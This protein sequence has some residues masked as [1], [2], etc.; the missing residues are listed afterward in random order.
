MPRV[1]AVLLIAM[2]ATLI[3]VGLRQASRGRETGRWTRTTA[4]ILES[5]VDRLEP[6]DEQPWERFALVIRYTYE[7]RGHRR[8]SRQVWIGSTGVTPSDHPAALLRWV[9]RFPAGSEAP[10]WFDPADPAEAVLVRRIPRG[11]VGV[12]LSVG[13]VLAAAGLY[14]LARLAWP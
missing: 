3:V 4:R 1:V 12:M 10:A 13:A 5:R 2:G 7:A 11:H 6:T 14:A 9:D 8:E